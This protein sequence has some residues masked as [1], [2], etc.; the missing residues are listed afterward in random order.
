[1]TVNIFV[2]ILNSTYFDDQTKYNNITKELAWFDG[3]L[4]VWDWVIIKP[5]RKQKYA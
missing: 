5:L 4:R 2:H 1:M 3:A